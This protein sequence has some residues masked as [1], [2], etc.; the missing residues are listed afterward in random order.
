MADI[1]LTYK[2]ATISEI[3]ASGTTTI[4]TAGK[5][6]EDN[7]TLSYVQ[8]GGGG[9]ADPF[10]PKLDGKTHLWFQ[11]VSAADL[12]VKI[13]VPGTVTV[14]WG[15]GNSN[16]STV[17]TNT[18]TYASVG[19]FDVSFPL[20]TYWGNSTYIPYKYR[21]KLIAAELAYALSGTNGL[22]YAY[23]LQSAYLADGT[24]GSYVNSL[25]YQSYGLQKCR[26][27]QN[28]TA[29][30]NDMFRECYSLSSIDIPPE[31]TSIG[32][33]AFQYCRALETVTIPS[34]VTSIGNGAFQYCVSITE[35]HIKPASPPTI[36]TNSF[37][38]GSATRFYVPSAS[39]ST[40][41]TASGWSTFASK[42]IG[43]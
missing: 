26:L 29:I 13:Y 5:Y 1:T 25:F 36:G 37:Y 8:P 18:H 23:D 41:K 7:I 32:S 10:T 33:T 35:Y 17:G 21:N 27:D 34:K 14:D 16:T 3:S 2:G 22:S 20:G 19:L 4:E 30:G 28:I 40:Y 31:V 39:L 43:E 24:I 12:T 11:L 6:C 38:N 42:M 9:G 15:D